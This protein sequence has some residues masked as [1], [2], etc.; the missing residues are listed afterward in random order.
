MKYRTALFSFILFF[1][2]AVTAA[3]NTALLS[4]EK[5]TLLQQQQNV[6]DSQHEKLRT[7]WIA[8]INLNASYEY[9]KSALGDYHSD[10]KSTSV[11]VSQDIFRSGGITYQI[12][13]ADANMRTN[14]V[15]LNKQIAALNQQ[16]FTALLNLQ[17]SLLQ[18]EQSKLRLDNKEIEIFIRRHLYD[19]GKADITEL[20]NA[21]MTKST[22]LKTYATAKY[23]ISEQR[24]E[25]TKVSNI[26]PENFPIPHFELILKEDFLQN[27]FDVQY[28]RAQTNTLA[29]LYDV[30]R[31]NYLPS[32]AFNGNIGY[33]SYAP[34]ELSGSYRGDY[35]SAGLSL[36]LPLVYNASSTVQEAKASYLQ[37]LAATADKRR[38]LE[39]TYRQSLEK[40]ESYRE[41]ITIT[42][43]NLFLYDDLIQATQAGVDAGTKTGYDLQTLKNSKKVEE[44]EIKINE[45]NIQIELAKLYF[46]LKTSK[47]TL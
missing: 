11:S 19:V 1:P 24:F 6:Y 3:D 15:L 13:Y 2:M 27:Q 31:T 17:K 8:P 20:N 39:A 25:I 33:R 28:A 38:E 32:L 41:Y 14:S 46:S 34:K 45:I 12:D 35:Y 37:E 26:D 29:K 21:L 43:N 22:E 7:N 16:L 30:T 47:D 40:I 42:A 4:N 44:L 23:T 18:L 9:D 10:M 5:Q 36:T